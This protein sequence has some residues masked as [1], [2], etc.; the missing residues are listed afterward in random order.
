MLYTN[1]EATTDSRL[2]ERLTAPNPTIGRPDFT[3]AV[4]LSFLVF[5]LLYCPCMATVTAIAR[6]TGSWR[7]ATFSAVYNTALAWVAAFA[8][9]RLMLL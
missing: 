3:P 7:Y 4:A 9:Y 5:V 1:D 6:E 2:G 8:V